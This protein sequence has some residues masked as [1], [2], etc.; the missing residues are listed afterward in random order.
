MK[1]LLYVSTLGL[2]I[3]TIF[4]VRTTKE[5]TFLMIRSIY[6]YY[7]V[8]DGDHVNV[9]LYASQKSEQLLDTAIDRLQLASDNIL[10]DVFYIDMTQ[11]AEE[12][13]LNH[14]YYIYTLTFKLPILFQTQTIEHASL[15]MTTNLGQT[16]QMILGHFFITPYTSNYS[17]DW[18][19][20]YVTRHE[21]L[22]TLLSITI[23]TSDT[24]EIVM[25]GHINAS[26]SYEEKHIK[27]TIHKNDAIILSPL[28][29]IRSIH[30]E[31]MIAGMTFI[32]SNRM[33][34]QTEGY[35]YVY[36]LH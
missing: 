32:Q 20:I 25:L 36:A 21:T 8:I 28:I 2:I 35:H 6:T 30:G 17:H 24:I 31:E 18:T 26:V 29:M 12:T 15:K 23:E 3:L 5:D 34:N 7:Q 14:R 19:S 11:D 13:Y 16:H 1:L 33:L 9:Q 10:M 4:I 27:I 22:M